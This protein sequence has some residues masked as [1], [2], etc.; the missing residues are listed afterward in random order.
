MHEEE[1]YD[2]DPWEK[3]ASILKIPKEEQEEARVALKEM[4]YDCME[5]DGGG[6]VE[7]RLK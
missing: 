4:I 7:I 3:L 5:D 1:E 6:G 2:Y